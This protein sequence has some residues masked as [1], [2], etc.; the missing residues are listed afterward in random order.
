L[1]SFFLKKPRPKG[2]AQRG[3]FQLSRRLTTE[4]KILKMPELGGISDA[5]VTLFKILD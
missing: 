1:A 3:Q 4:K 2:P 5:I